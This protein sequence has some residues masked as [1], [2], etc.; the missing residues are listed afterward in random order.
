[1]SRNIKAEIL[2]EKV[3]FSTKKEA[4]QFSKD[5]KIYFNRSIK[6]QKDRR[7]NFIKR[8]REKR[9]EKIINDKIKNVIDDFI[10][11][12]KQN[13]GNIPTSVTLTYRNGK[14]ETFKIPNE[15]IV[16]M[17]ESIETNKNQ[18][19]LLELNPLKI[20]RGEPSERVFKIVSPGMIKDMIGDNFN[21]D[22]YNEIIEDEVGNKTIK[23]IIKN[24]TIDKRNGNFFKYAINEEIEQLKDIEEILNRYQIYIITPE[25]NTACLIHSLEKSGVPKDKLND[26]MLSTKTG[27]I[28]SKLLEDFAIKNDY[29]INLLIDK[30]NIS[31]S[32]VYGNKNSKNIINLGLIEEHYFINEPVNITSYSI[33]NFDKVKNRKRWNE[34]VNINLEKKSGS[35]TLKREKVKYIGKNGSG[36]NSFKLIK[37]L[38]NT[39]LLVKL[40]LSDNILKLT[41]YKEL[42][43]NGLE[44]SDDIKY[45]TI[46]PK[47]NINEKIDIRKKIIKNKFN[48]FINKNELNNLI[49]SIKEDRSKFYFNV[50]FD[51]EASTNN[52]IHKEY[53]V[54]YCI[55]SELYDGENINDICIDKIKTVK[56]ENCSN[57]FLTEVSNNIYKKGYDLIKTFLPKLKLNTFDNLKHRRF[58]KE[59]INN[60]MKITFIAHN[61]TYDFSFLLK[62]VFRPSIFKRAN[63]FVTGGEFFFKGI[64][65]NIKDSYGIIAVGL[66][67][68]GGMFKLK[69]EKEIMPYSVYNEKNCFTKDKI[70]LT[71]ALNFIKE[72]KREMFINKIKDLKLLINDDYFDHIK[73]AEY[74]CKIDVK[75]MI[76]GYHTMKKW[77]ME[78]F[79]ANDKGMDINNYLTISSIACDYLVLNKCFDNVYKIGGVSRYFIQKSVIGGRCMSSNNMKYNIEEKLQDFDAVSLYPSAIARLST[80]L[81]G[82]LKGLPKLLTNEMKNMDFLNKTDGYFVRIKL[83]KITKKYNFPLYNYESK[84]GSRTFSNELYEDIYDDKGNHVKRLDRSISFQSKISLEDLINFCE[85]KEQDFEILDGYYFN[86]GRNPLIGINIIK[87]FNERIKKKKQKSA[88]QVLYKL[89]MNSAY[90]FTILKEQDKEHIYKDGEEEMSKFLVN[91]FHRKPIATEVINDNDFR[92]FEITSDKE[93]SDHYNSCHVGSEI[94][95]MSKRIMNEVMCL[96]EDNGIKIYYQDTDSMHIEDEKIS[97]LSEIFKNKYGRELIGENMGQFHSDFE[98]PKKFVGYKALYSDK[99]I[100]LGKKSYLDRVI[101]YKIGDDSNK[102]YSFYYHSR[103]KGIPKDV[104]KLNV[105]N[106]YNGN[107][108]KL[109][110]HLYNN[111]TCKFNLNAVKQKIKIEKDGTNRNVTNFNRTISF[112][113]RNNKNEYFDE[114]EFNETINSI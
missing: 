90:G 44:L 6:N 50:F 31:N 52:I 48:N 61:I 8:L 68:F 39:N 109:Y 30:N 94:L 78:D 20:N 72:S 74:Y 86:E 12:N 96:S 42:L 60:F 34:I 7:N 75:V 99:T 66:R 9:N 27:C 55:L 43:N 49:N 82:I 76:D 56:G 2:K 88:V 93:I 4:L 98:P 32:K 111:G 103:M 102:E 59:F 106:N 64:R 33:K 10:K 45:N 79:K 108:E 97:K 53:M 54:C 37:Q 83:N 19:I 22:Y 3:G 89:M 29:R 91:N 87:M 17:L 63:K 21:D 28:H 100:I 71:K 92:R 114:E 13:S 84:N 51:F 80:D 46:N 107:Y 113:D 58:I 77:L 112:I 95:A 41:N 65:F 101:I 73:Y 47:K 69:Q 5:N 18:K 40:K 11:E 81:G 35:K 110:L 67:E 70:K 25:D 26:L 16:T 23:F 57:K 62:H 15:S 38:I 36:N 14:K 1:M 24:K 105:K 104:L 85:I